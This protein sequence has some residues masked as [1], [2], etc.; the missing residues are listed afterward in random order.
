VELPAIWEKKLR[1]LGLRHRLCGRDFEQHEASVYGQT[2][3]AGSIV[4]GNV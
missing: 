3:E 2:V 1:E 4:I